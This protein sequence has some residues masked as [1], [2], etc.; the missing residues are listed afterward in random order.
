MLTRGTEENIVTG[1]RESGF[2]EGVVSCVSMVVTGPNK[3]SLKMALV[4][5]I[6]SLVILGQSQRQGWGQELEE[7]KG[8]GN[9]TEKRC[10]ES[11]VLKRGDGMRKGREID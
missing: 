11:L 7:Q 6:K 10:L 9:D 2:G 3:L 8:C 1:M 5:E 4:Y